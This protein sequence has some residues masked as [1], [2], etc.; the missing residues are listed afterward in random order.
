MGHC[1]L[2]ARVVARRRS[3]AGAGLP[4]AAARAEPAAVLALLWSH[5]GA[6][7]AQFSRQREGGR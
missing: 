3:A 6:L 2:A 5:R 7:L 1:E 4:G